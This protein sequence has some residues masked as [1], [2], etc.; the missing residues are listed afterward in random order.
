MTDST[1]PA[2]L[3]DPTPTTI[4][5]P[6]TATNQQLK[7]QARI[8]MSVLAGALLGRLVSGHIL[9]ASLDSEPVVDALT[10]M[11]LYGLAAFWTWAR[12]N[13]THT[14]FLTLAINPRVPNDLVTTTTGAP[15]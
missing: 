8:V 3:A 1:D 2:A 6:P 13:L 4:V 7:G 9:P 12:V 14:R 15:K 5:V 10:G 11:G